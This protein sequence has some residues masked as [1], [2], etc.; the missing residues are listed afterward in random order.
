MMTSF[1]PSNC[2]AA[3]KPD[4][5]HARGD[6]SRFI[7]ARR[8]TWTGS[9]SGWRA[10][11]TSFVY[12]IER[13]ARGVHLQATPIDVS[14]IFETK[15]LDRVDTIVLTSATLPSR[16]DLSLRRSVSG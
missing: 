12:W 6:H 10:R 14:P 2:R 15:I 13:R 16:A 11:R 9:A 4:Q 7:D 5:E 1:A 3:I 8:S